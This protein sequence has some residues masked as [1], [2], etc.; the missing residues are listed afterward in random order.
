M[1]RDV[2]SEVLCQMETPN[3][4]HMSE[5]TTTSFVNCN[6]QWREKYTMRGNKKSVYIETISW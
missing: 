2:M 6:S 1:T 4:L 3:I 5:C